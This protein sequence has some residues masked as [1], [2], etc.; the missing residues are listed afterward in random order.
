M[1][2]NYNTKTAQVIQH[3]I[4]T[5]ENQQFSVGD[6]VS[7]MEEN[8]CKV[9]LTTIYRNL[10]KLVEKN[11]IAKYKTA[12][13]DTYQY[14][15]ERADGGCH[16]HLHLHC[17]MC[18]KIFHMN[19]EIMARFQQSLMDEYGFQLECE[20]SVLSGLCSECAKLAKA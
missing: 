6:V 8:D 19:C 3:F 12:N 15:I 1:Q 10:D 2:K 5:H 9:N 16:S 17:R 13:S 7:Y 4:D 20:S 18:G 11:K 14:R